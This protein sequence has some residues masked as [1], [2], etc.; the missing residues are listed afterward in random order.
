MIDL[1]GRVIIVTG[2]SSGIGQSVA[3][4]ASRA[5]A[6]VALIGRDI[7][8]LRETYDSIQNESRIFS[9]DLSKDIDNISLTVERIRDTMGPIWGLVHAAGHHLVSP[10]RNIEES[11]F[12]DLLKI[13]VTVFFELAKAV[14]HKKNIDVR[15]G[16]LVAIASMAA[17]TGDV[18]L[19]QYGAAKGALISA[20]RSLALECAPRKIRFN[21]ISPA[22]VQ[23]PMFQKLAAYYPDQQSFAHS[24][25]ARH[26]LG[27]GR[28][29]DVAGSAVFLLSDMASWITGTNLIVDGG[30]SLG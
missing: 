4:Y 12:S 28:P 18:G 6:R 1:S 5:G 26:P 16:S 29:D 23:T 21:C 8:R 27:L 15:G 9:L 20:V 19:S 22:M 24:F 3:F 25:E 13:N 2:A 10:L 11:S 14:C 30:Y 7:N 17:V